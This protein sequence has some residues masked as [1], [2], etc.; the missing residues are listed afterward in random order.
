MLEP[1][2]SQAKSIDIPLSPIVLVF[3]D[4]LSAAHKSSGRSPSHQRAGAPSQKLPFDRLSWSTV[5]DGADQRALRAGRG[6]H[7]ARGAQGHLP[8][9]RGRPQAA[10]R[11]RARATARSGRSWCRVA[12]PAVATPTPISCLRRSPRARTAP[13]YNRFLEAPRDEPAP[14]PLTPR[15]S[16]HSAPSTSRPRRRRV[17]RAR[18]VQRPDDPSGPRCAGARPAAGRRAAAAPTA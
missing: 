2:L 9:L 1:V 18:T 4:A 11:R 3:A 15:P 8:A 6:L 13:R 12:R 14:T 10:R 5:P 16:P 17:R 7:H